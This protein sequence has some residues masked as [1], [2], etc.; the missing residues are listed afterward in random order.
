M[1]L[2]VRATPSVRRDRIPVR[3]IQGKSWARGLSGFRFVE[4][5]ISR[6]PVLLSAARLFTE[7]H[8]H[9]R[10]LQRLGHFPSQRP[11]FLQTG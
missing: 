6:A 10:T 5:V 8:F 4:F 2:R 1:T 11:A 7:Q 9:H 3:E